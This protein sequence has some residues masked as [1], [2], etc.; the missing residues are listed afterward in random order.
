MKKIKL[1]KVT[2]W[3]NGQLF[4]SQSYGMWHRVVW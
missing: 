3:R 1:A 2:E 4:R